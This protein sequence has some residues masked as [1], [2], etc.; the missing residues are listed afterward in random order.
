MSEN[1][2]DQNPNW[3]VG[4]KIALGTAVAVIA[5]SNGVADLATLAIF[6]DVSGIDDLS[7]PKAATF[8]M[9]AAMTL[10]ITLIRTRDK[11]SD[12]TVN[13]VLQVVSACLAFASG[14]YWLESELGDPVRY[15]RAVASLG[16][17]LSISVL[18]GFGIW[19]PV[20][21]V[22]GWLQR[23]LLQLLMRRSS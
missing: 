14:L 19:I 6:I 3:L 1:D 9:C 17:V 7:G 18:V 20:I 4:L 8:A 5:A 15:V 13:Q 21:R 2:I 23:R 22:L 12:R 16:A 10:S 11:H